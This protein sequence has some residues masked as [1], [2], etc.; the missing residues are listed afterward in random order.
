[1]MRF[2]IESSLSGCCFR[3]CDVQGQASGYVWLGF[4][5]R[6]SGFLGGFENR[7]KNGAGCALMECG[8]RNKQIYKQE[9]EMNKEL[10]V[11]FVAR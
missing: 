9:T 8:R 7:M 10:I 4:Q 3:E 6:F 11:Y 5:G 1:M 2:S